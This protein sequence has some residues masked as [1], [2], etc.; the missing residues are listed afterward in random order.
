MTQGAP[1]A[2]ASHSATTHTFDPQAL[3]VARNCSRGDGCD[4]GVSGLQVCRQAAGRKCEVR[5]CTGN[6]SVATSQAGTTVTATC[7]AQTTYTR[8]CGDCKSG[9]VCVTQQAVR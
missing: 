4:V 5:V 8:G 9:Q 2:Q 6:S 7:T 3:V 1:V